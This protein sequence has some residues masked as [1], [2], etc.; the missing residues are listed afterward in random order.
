VPYESGVVPGRL[1]VPPGEQMLAPLRWRA[2]S[3]ANDPNVA[4]SIQ[5]IAVP[6]AEPVL[7]DVTEHESSP[8]GLD[9][10]DGGDVYLGPWAQALEGWSRHGEGSE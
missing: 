3:T 8:V 1:V 5:V 7:L 4:V 6:G 9:I 2:M 10:M